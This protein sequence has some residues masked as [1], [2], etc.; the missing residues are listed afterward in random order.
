MAGITG[1]A[2]PGLHNP[3]SDLARMAAPI[4]FTPS[5]T[6][7]AADLGSLAAGW[8]DYGPGFEF[9][10]PAHAR[11]GNVLLVMEGEVYVDPHEQ[12]A[13]AGPDAGPIRRAPYCLQ[14]YQRLGPEFVKRLNGSFAIAILDGDGRQIH[15]YTDRFLSR[16]L[17]VWQQ[18]EELAFASSIRSLL[19]WRD[20]VGRSYDSLGLAELVGLGR[21]V[22]DRTLLADITRLGPAC[23]AHWDGRRLLR[24]RYHVFSPSAPPPAASAADA[25]RQLVHLLGKAMGQRCS[26]NAPAGLFVSGGIDSRLLLSLVPQDVRG[27]TLTNEGHASRERRLAMEV[28]RVSRHAYIE[29]ARP[30][31]NTLDNA[32]AAPDLVEGQLWF[33]GC[34]C[35]AFFGRL[36]QEGVRVAMT[37]LYFNQLLKGHFLPAGLSHDGA[38]PGASLILHQRLARQ[39]ADGPLVRRVHHLDL[40][41][42]AMSDQMR[43]A[44]AMAKDRQVRRL[45]EWLGQGG[46]VEDLADRFCLDNLF[47]CGGIA[48]FLRSNQSCLVE[49]SPAYDNNLADFAMSLPSRWKRRGGIVRQALC[50]SSPALARLAD[51]N[52]HLPAG[53]HGLWWSLLVSPRQ[54]AHDTG[55]RL[56]RHFRPL[57]RIRRSGRHPFT[58]GAYHDTNALL[59]V[60]PEYRRLVEDAIDQLPDGCFDRGRLRELLAGDAA[61]ERPQLNN[62]F[63]AVVTLGQFNARWGPDAPRPTEPSYLA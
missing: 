31:T 15:L 39:L 49:R 11:C 16:P 34:R 2:A 33:L 29:L 38:A 54:W 59:K 18:G 35:A 56:S 1:L 55:R 27:I 26:D 30:A 44:L 19:C 47:A 61:A 7:G 32:C 41:A 52:T 24:R 58:Q 3:Q 23:H 6:F 25:S 51:P 36:L 53:T 46:T 22:S 42:L 63:E 8:V 37:G 50:L 48:S 60:C 14:M 28:F 43:D 10:Q 5:Q 45:A 62:L 9:L 20:T 17:F 57:R 13:A 40:L 12:D 4:R 21:I